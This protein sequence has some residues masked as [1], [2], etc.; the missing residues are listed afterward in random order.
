MVTVTW[1]GGMAFEGVGPSGQ[2]SQFDAYPD[3]GGEGAAPTPLEGFLAA[4]GACG[5][6]DVISIL[7][8]KRQVVTSYRIEVEGDRSPAGSPFPRPYTAIRVRHILVG[9]NLDGEAVARAVELSDEKYCSVVATLRQSPPITSE[10]V[11]ETP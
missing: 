3:A 9:E 7:Q 8:K 5:A 11:V 1:K 10:W 2:A 6:M 4:L